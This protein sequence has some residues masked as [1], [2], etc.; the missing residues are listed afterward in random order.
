MTRPRCTSRKSSCSQT[1]LNS[2]TLILFNP[3]IP[4][5]VTGSIFSTIS[6]ITPPSSLVCLVA[7]LSLLAFQ[8]WGDQQWNQLFGICSTAL[9]QFYCH[10]QTIWRS[11]VP[12]PAS[13]V[14]TKHDGVKT[15][16]TECFLYFRY[17]L[18]SAAHNHMVNVMHVHRAHH[19]RY[20][21]VLLW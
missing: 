1:S 4:A 19:R 11:D 12:L 10:L 8:T 7:S 21:L 15:K 18:M 14:E 3:G 20:E 5:T 16:R 17:Q 13:H 2:P 9:K 6:Q